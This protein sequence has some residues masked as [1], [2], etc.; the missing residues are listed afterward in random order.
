M[1]TTKSISANVTKNDGGSA[2]QV[3]TSEVLSSLSLGL[4]NPA[5]GSVVVDGTDTDKSVD[6]AVFAK[7]T[8]RP[9]GQR[10]TSPLVS[11]SN[12]PTYIRS[13][14]GIES[15]DSP[16]TATAI[17]AGYWNIYSGQWS[18]DPTVSYDDMHKAVSGTTNI[19]NNVYVSRSNTGSLTFLNGSK[20]PVNQSYD[21]KRG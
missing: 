5:T 15:F 10:L 12:Y 7:N 9:L 14:N 1:A 3:G 18:T 2:V 8:Q 20:N 21:S 17:R 6:S 13:V 4:T 19:D 11:A 16:G